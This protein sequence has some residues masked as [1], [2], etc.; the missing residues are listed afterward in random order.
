MGVI[1]TQAGCVMG[2]G[3]SW[4]LRRWVKS[5]S[6]ATRI[7]FEDITRQSGPFSKEKTKRVKTVTFNTTVRYFYGAYLSCNNTVHFSASP[8][9]IINDMI[10]LFSPPVLQ[11]EF[12]SHP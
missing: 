8:E 1:S 10:L 7:R 3:G 11:F 4:E 5:L 6:N 2:G 12:L 9:L